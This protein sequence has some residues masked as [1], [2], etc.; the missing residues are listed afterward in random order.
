MNRKRLQRNCVTEAKKP[1][2]K[3]YEIESNY[4]IHS[5]SHTY[6]GTSS[7]LSDN[8]DVVN[9]NEE[10]LLKVCLIMF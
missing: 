4:E 2:T 9:R 5:D 6:T 10:F 8:S 1:F 3:L 7:E